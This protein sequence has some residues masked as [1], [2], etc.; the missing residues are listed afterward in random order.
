M[1]TTDISKMGYLERA[2]TVK[3]FQAWNKNG[4]PEDF[5][6]DQITLNFNPNSG[7]IF[8]CNSD[9]QSAILDGDQLVIIDE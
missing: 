4:L 5:T 9:C 8:L 3:L 7:Y 6:E 1:D 2:R